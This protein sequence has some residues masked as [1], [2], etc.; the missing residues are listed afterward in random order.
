MG[1]RSYLKTFIIIIIIIKCPT[2]YR[3]LRRA[4]K[5]LSPADYPYLLDYHPSL[6]ILLTLRCYLRTLGTNSLTGP[7]SNQVCCPFYTV[8]YLNDTEGLAMN[9][10]ITIPQYGFMTGTR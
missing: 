6:T 10:K 5:A 9:V 4:A 1:G 7:S 2:P 8:S 3:S